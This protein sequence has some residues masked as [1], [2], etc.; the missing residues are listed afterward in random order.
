MNIFRPGSGPEN[1]SRPS[2]KNPVY[3]SYCRANPDSNPTAEK[4]P[5]SGFHVII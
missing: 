5:G 1:G 2:T 4:Q 3:E